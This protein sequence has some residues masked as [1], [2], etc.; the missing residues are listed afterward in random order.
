[1][2]ASA[3]IDRSNGLVMDIHRLGYWLVPWFYVGREMYFLQETVDAVPTREKGP[4][5]VSKEWS[6]DREIIESQ[7]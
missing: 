3:G 4:S 2:A 5:T 6:L 1:M 7:R